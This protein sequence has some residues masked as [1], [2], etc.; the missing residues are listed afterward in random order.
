MKDQGILSH[1]ENLYPTRLSNRSNPIEGR[2]QMAEHLVRRADLAQG[3]KLSPANSLVNWTAG[4][5]TAAAGHIK[6]AGDISLQGCLAVPP[7]G[8]RL[9]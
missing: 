1:P 3:R 6:R 4:M 7:T 2:A 5:E 8:H 9:G